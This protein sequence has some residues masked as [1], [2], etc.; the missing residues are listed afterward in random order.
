MMRKLL[1]LLFIAL[2]VA[3]G[4]TQETNDQYLF[5]NRIKAL[6]GKSFE[7]KVTAGNRNDDFSKNRLVMHIRSCD[8]NRIR[9]PFFVGEDRS[10]T[11][12]LTYE[13][14]QIQLKHDHRHEDGSED[15]VTQYGGV[16]PNAGCDSIQMFPA[17]VFTRD[18]YPHT[19]NNVWWI[20]IDDKIFTY[21]LRRIGSD[22][23]FT[24]SFDLTKEVP[25]PDAPWGWID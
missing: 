19:A 2:S 5:L 6:C 23:V 21:N 22:R 16:T 24:V 25:T 11:W 17:D 7:G 15:T 14:N 10:R 3:R 12:I 1:L 4:Y 20:T 18:S 9:I 13:N 8:G